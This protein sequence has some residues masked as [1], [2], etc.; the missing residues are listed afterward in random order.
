VRS[1]STR[2]AHDF[3]TALYVGGSS[4][5]STSSSDYYPQTGFYR[6]YHPASSIPQIAFIALD[7]V[8]LLVETPEAS[9]SPAP[10]RNPTRSATT[11]PD[12]SRSLFRDASRETDLS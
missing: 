3:L 1:S 5:S 9:S 4:L 8:T 11:I 2:L 6:P 10:H 7:T 12:R